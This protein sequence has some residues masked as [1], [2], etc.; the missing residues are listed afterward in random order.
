MCPLE[1]FPF[2][3]NLVSSSLLIIFLVLFSKG[4]LFCSKIP[5]PVWIAKIAWGLASSIVYK[6]SNTP[7]SSVR[8]ALLKKGPSFFSSIVIVFTLPLKISCLNSEASLLASSIKS[9]CTLEI[10]LVGSIPLVALLGSATFHLLYQE[11]SCIYAKGF[12]LE[13]IANIGTESINS[14]EFL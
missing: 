2:S 11:V 5:P 9:A 10:G 6:G 4:I 3:S 12:P 7:F 14:W 1:D 13:S 8:L